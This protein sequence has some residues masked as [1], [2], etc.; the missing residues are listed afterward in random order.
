LVIR[1]KFS[2]TALPTCSSF[3]A[4]P[5]VDTFGVKEIGFAKDSNA[6]YKTTSDATIVADVIIE[7]LCFYLY[8][9]KVGF[10]SGCLGILLHANQVERINFHPT[11]TRAAVH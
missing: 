2:Y 6:R 8:D 1:L 10:C 9:V 5:V 3:R 4:S 7:L 11:S